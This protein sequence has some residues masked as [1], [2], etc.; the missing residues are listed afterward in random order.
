APA[1]DPAPARTAPVRC[2]SVPAGPT[3]ARRALRG[4]TRCAAWPPGAA[5]A[6]SPASA[7]PATGL[8]AAALVGAAVLT[9]AAVVTGILLRRVPLRSDVSG[10]TSTSAVSAEQR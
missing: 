9:V 3:G 4:S 2:A 5:A 1:R 7:R 8:T 10:T 6:G